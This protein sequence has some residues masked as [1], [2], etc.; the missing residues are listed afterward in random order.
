MIKFSSFALFVGLTVLSGC[1][2]TYTYDGKKYNSAAEFHSAVDQDLSMR[3]STVTPLKEPL[4][5]KMLVVAYASVNAMEA[6]NERRFN[7]LNNASRPANTKEMQRNLSIF[8]H[9]AISSD[10]NSIK[11][12]NIYKSVECR[13]MDQTVLDI[14]ASDAYDTFFFSESTEGTG[15]WLYVSKKH[16]KQVFAFDKSSLEPAARVRNYLSAVEALA[17]RN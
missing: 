8:Y 12:R 16:G 14:P 3:R 15:Q 4:T 17:I 2:T 1:A 5:D 6:E 13:E 9:K 7:K 11:L 10:C